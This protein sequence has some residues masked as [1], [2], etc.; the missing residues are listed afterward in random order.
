MASRGDLARPRQVQSGAKKMSKIFLLCLRFVSVTVENRI[1]DV[2]PIQLVPE[3]RILDY[4]TVFVTFRMRLFHQ[5][6][7]LQEN[8]LNLHVNTP[9]VNKRT[10]GKI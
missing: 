7:S 10:V 3:F 8:S 1:H 2:A 5:H 4:G 9:R 6:C